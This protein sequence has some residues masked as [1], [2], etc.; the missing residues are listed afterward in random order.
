MVEVRVYHSSIGVFVETCSAGRDYL[1]SERAGRPHRPCTQGK[2]VCISSRYTPKNEK[3]GFVMD[4]VVRQ[5]LNSSLFVNRLGRN[6]F[7]SL[8]CS[9]NNDV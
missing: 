8:F 9:Q 4:L 7:S 5:V 2:G 1:A 3:S 6:T